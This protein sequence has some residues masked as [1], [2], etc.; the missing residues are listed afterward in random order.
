MDWPKKLTQLWVRFMSNHCQSCWITLAPFYLVLLHP[1]VPSQLHFHTAHHPLEKTPVAHCKGSVLVVS[2]V[3]LQHFCLLLFSFNIFVCFTLSAR[4]IPPANN[5]SL[6][7]AP[8]FTRC[9]SWIPVQSFGFGFFSP[10][11]LQFFLVV[12]IIFTL[13]FRRATD[14]EGWFDS[15][16]GCFCMWLS[17]KWSLL[18]AEEVSKPWAAVNAQL[19]L[20]LC[21]RHFFPLLLMCRNPARKIIQLSYGGSLF[22]WFVVLR[23]AQK[24]QS[25]FCLQTTWASCLFFWQ[26]QGR[27]GPLVC[28]LVSMWEHG[29]ICSAWHCLCCVQDAETWILWLLPLWELQ[30][31]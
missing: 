14:K 29:D 30:E 1:Y 7:S 20:W 6:P 23:A 5:R 3:F 17:H 31:N 11:P 2:L 26:V 27:H 25:E 19:M 9:T 21:P 16:S 18:G 13:C 12:R 10:L 24:L 4:C 15:G 28:F 8:L 22:Q